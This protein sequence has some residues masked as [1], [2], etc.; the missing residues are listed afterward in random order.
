MP[1]YA[2]LC[3]VKTGRDIPG[4]LYCTRPNIPLPLLPKCPS[5]SDK[6]TKG[7]K[8]IQGEEQKQQTST[9]IYN[10]YDPAHWNIVPNP[11][12]ADGTPCRAKFPDYKKFRLVEWPTEE[13]PPLTGFAKLPGEL[14]NRIWELSLPDPKLV[15]LTPI[16]YR[17]SIDG[18]ADDQDSYQHMFSCKDSLGIF[19]L[20]YRDIQPLEL[21]REVLKQSGMYNV[22]DFDHR[23]L[24]RPIY[25][26]GARDV[27]VVFETGSLG[28]LSPHEWSTTPLVL[29]GIQSLAFVKNGGWDEG[30]VFT[31]EFISSFPSLKSLTCILNYPPTSEAGYE[32]L[33]TEA[34]EVAGLTSLRHRQRF[35]LVPM[36]SQLCKSIKVSKKRNE[37][38][39]SAMWLDKS[40]M[41][42]WRRMATGIYKD[43]HSLP[44][45]DSKTWDFNCALICREDRL[46][47]WQSELLY[48]QP[49]IS[50]DDPRAKQLAHYTLRPVSRCA[51]DHPKEPVIIGIP[52][53]R[54]KCEG[55]WFYWD[56]QFVARESADPYEGLMNFF[57][58]ENL[59]QYD[60]LM[61]VFEEEDS[62][63]L[64]Q[65]ESGIHSRRN[66]E[67]TA[68]YEQDGQKDVVFLYRPA[69]LDDGNPPAYLL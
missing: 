56:Q 68:W 21:A 10:F 24:L 35:R 39:E 47:W 61:R 9:N 69:V 41:N 20:Y 4:K 22:D 28:S 58:E 6:N 37:S 46:D 64:P 33:S 31:E 5:D 52:Y 27:V 62:P 14:R 63:E 53:D 26:D 2:G 32:S 19:R 42:E 25:V 38:R 66:L 1:S 13:I 60:G 7:A 67:L 11:T 18:L 8:A 16:G 49:N 65:E 15:F 40:K 34:G 3:R 36:N 55:E 29:D 43:L 50:A 48:L 17:Y 59:D 45:A 51:R 30:E 54:S 23:K 44:I 57:G 12:Y